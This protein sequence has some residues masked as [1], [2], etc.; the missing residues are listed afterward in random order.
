MIDDSLAVE[1]LIEAVQELSLARDLTSVMAIV[2]TAA[3]RLVHADGATFVLRDGDLCHYADEDAISPLWKG[4]RFP[5]SACISGWSMLH[6]EA[7]A[8]PDIYADPRIPMDAYRPTFVKSLVMVPIRATEPV[9]AIGT[10]WASHHHATPGEIRLLSSLANSTSIALE[11]VQ[12]YAELEQRVQQRTADLVRVQRQKDEL[13]QLIVHDLRSPATGIMMASKLRLRDRATSEIDRQRWQNVHVSAEAIHRMAMNLL[14]IMRN[15]DGTFAPRLAQVA[16]RKLIF[17][18][19]EQMMPVAVGNGCELAFDEGNVSSAIVC[20]EELV[21]RVL[22]NLLDNAIRHA[23]E[24][25][26]VALHAGR[27]DGWLELR[28]LDEG[29]G[30]PPEMRESVFHKGVQLGSGARERGGRGL[31]LAFCQLAVASHGGSIAIESNMPRGSI[32]TVRL[33]VEQ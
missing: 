22:Q 24:G 32:V 5:L 12:L 6:R 28:V 15:E 7:V 2:R 25:S 20:D 17:D 27:A 13:A 4:Q 16:P 33:P 9:G 19:I 11:N 10:Y 31:G 8:I 26:R 23:P 30:I 1:Q 14:D 21:R 18:A 29:P 3:R